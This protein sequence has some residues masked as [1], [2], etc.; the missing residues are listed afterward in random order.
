[1]N[2]SFLIFLNSDS[3]LYCEVFQVII[4]NNIAVD[5]ESSVN[6]KRI[7]FISNE[8]SFIY[9]PSMSFILSTIGS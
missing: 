5:T 3:V 1:M 6:R 2:G 9:L 8:K 4:F 7:R